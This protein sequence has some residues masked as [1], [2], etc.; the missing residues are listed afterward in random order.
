MGNP[1]RIS[2]LKSGVHS[3]N[4]W[5]LE[6]PT[7]KPDLSRAELKGLDLCESDLHAANLST[8][9]LQ[10]SNLLDADLHGANTAEVRLMGADATRANFDNAELD[11]AL[12]ND[13]RAWYA[14]FRKY[15][16]RPEGR[17]KAGHHAAR[18]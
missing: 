13:A 18:L 15:K 8:A 3:W 14:T 17:K 4:R 9:E 6:N 5:R 10:W 2:I 16:M 1:D 12:I 7:V 11:G